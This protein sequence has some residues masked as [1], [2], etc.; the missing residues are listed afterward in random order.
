MKITSYRIQ[1]HQPRQYRRLFH[2]RNQWRWKSHL[3]K[4][5]GIHFKMAWNPQVWTDV[6]SLPRI[7]LCKVQDSC[8]RWLFKPCGKTM[9]LV[10][11]HLLHC[12]K[13]KNSHNMCE[14]N[15]KH[16]PDGGE[17]AAIDHSS[18]LNGPPG[19][20]Q[21]SFLLD[22]Q[23]KTSLVCFGSKSYFSPRILGEMI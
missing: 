20:L 3:K 6:F 11:F 10:V 12:Q 2:W 16:R 14:N 1:Q 17:A 8:Q 19:D 21:R 23:T 15:W 4:I 18:Q 5:M 13:L 9:L 22:R 7:L